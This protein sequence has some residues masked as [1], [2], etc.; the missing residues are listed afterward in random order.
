[1]KS[2][3]GVAISSH[4]EDSGIVVLLIIRIVGVAL[5]LLK[6]DSIHND[7]DSRRVVSVRKADT[8]SSDWTL[9]CVSLGFGL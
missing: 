4:G 9:H 1:L 5:H 3:P 2:V 7:V 8:E 6:P